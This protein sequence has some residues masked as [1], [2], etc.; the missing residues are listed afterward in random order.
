M[1]ISS[2]EFC[3]KTCFGATVVEPFARHLVGFILVGTV[4]G[5]AFRIFGLHERKS[6]WVLE[7]DF[8]ENFWVNVIWLFAFFFGLPDL[9]MLILLWFERSPHPAQVG[10]QSCP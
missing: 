7:H 10:R 5:K 4:F 2:W 8:R 9:I 1:T 3:R 6:R